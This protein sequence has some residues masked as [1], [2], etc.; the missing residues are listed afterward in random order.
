MQACC[1]ASLS[2]STW[3]RWVQWLYAGASD[4]DK[5]LSALARANSENPWGPKRSVGS[6]TSGVSGRA[7]GDQSPRLRGA[8][9]EI[10]IKV[11]CFKSTYCLCAQTMLERQY[12]HLAHHEPG[13]TNS[14][15][16]FCHYSCA[17]D[18]IYCDIVITV[19]CYYGCVCSVKH[20]I[21]NDVV[22]TALAITVTSFGC[23][24]HHHC[25]WCHIRQHHSWRLCQF[26]A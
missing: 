15:D 24:Q 18:N 14:D 16:K 1:K 21:H 19:G 20:K 7:R 4:S 17:S 12:L 11:C 10:Q 25:S 3:H 23:C 13:S 8:Y 6:F 2:L 22:V 26:W 5:D 9:A